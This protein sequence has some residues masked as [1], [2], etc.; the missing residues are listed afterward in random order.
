M[1]SS[2]RVVK[3]EECERHQLPTNRLTVATTQWKRYQM[4]WRENECLSRT[5]ASNGDVA[6]FTTSA[7]DVMDFVLKDFFSLSIQLTI[8]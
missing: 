4:P 2:Q 1:K 8:S 3:V 6:T 5:I 7:S